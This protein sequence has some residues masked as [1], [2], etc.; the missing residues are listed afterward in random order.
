MCSGPKDP[1][2]APAWLE[3]AAAVLLAVQVAIGL[4]SS[5]RR[6]GAHLVANPRVRNIATHLHRHGQT[7][8]IGLHSY[9][10][11]PSHGANHSRS[12]RVH[13]K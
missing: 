12:Q 5:A 9:G 8:E 2:L 10:E 11:Q 13:P 6:C 1:L 7:T 3:E 4:Q